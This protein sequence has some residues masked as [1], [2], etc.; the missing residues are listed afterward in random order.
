MKASV[1]ELIAYNIYFLDMIRI[2]QWYCQNLSQTRLIYK[3]E[4][5]DRNSK[6]MLILLQAVLVLWTDPSI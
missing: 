6:S 3:R 4:D 2:K 5:R 1:R